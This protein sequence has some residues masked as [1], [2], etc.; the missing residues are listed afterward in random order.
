MKDSHF[1]HRPCE[2][3]LKLKSVFNVTRDR[4]YALLVRLAIPDEG[5]A[6]LSVTRCS[7][8]RTSPLVRKSG[9]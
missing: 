3:I 5:R 9:E 6:G 7:Q 8:R 1:I 4:H 2:G